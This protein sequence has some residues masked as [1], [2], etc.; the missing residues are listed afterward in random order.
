VDEERRPSQGESHGDGDVRQVLG[1]AQSPRAPRAERLIAG[2]PQPMAPP[3]VLTSVRSALR[4]LSGTSDLGHAGEGGGDIISM[5][6]NQRIP[7][8]C[9]GRDTTTASRCAATPRR[10]TP[11]SRGQLELGGEDSNPQ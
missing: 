9:K 1:L 2:P 10:S 4:R 6:S 5:W 3:P 8:V 7:T 11:T